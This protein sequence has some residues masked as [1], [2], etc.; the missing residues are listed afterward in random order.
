MFKV[1]GQPFF[2][3]KRTSKKPFF[4]NQSIHQS[5][6]QSI[7]PS[8]NQ[9]I[10]PSIRPSIHPSVRPSIHP[11]IHPFFS[12]TAIVKPFFPAFPIRPLV[13]RPSPPLWRRW[14]ARRWK[15]LRSPLCFDGKMMA[16]MW[17]YSMK[18]HENPVEENQECGKHGET[19]WTRQQIW[20]LLSE[21]IVFFQGPCLKKRENDA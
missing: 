21:N 15:W 20:L 5:I 6:H 18:M 13:S 14:A 12:I 7:N 16:L 8:I 17:I 19:D 3:N 2:F 11:S 1:N 9:S 10:H 4:P